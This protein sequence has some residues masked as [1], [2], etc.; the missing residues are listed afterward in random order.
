[1][2]LMYHIPPHSTTNSLENKGVYIKMRKSSLSTTIFL[3]IFTFLLKK[4]HTSYY[5]FIILIPY[6]SIYLIFLIKKAISIEIAFN[7]LKSG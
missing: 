6:C 3:L 7:T 5:Y 1:M 4:L 2:K